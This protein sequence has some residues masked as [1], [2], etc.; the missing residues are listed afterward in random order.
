M[1]F[2]QPVYLHHAVWAQSLRKG[3]VDFNFSFFYPTVVRF[4]EGR[5]TGVNE[6]FVWFP[7]DYSWD[8]FD[9]D[10]YD[11]F[12]FH[13]DQ[14]LGATLFKEHAASVPLIAHSGR[15]WLY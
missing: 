6:Q 5:Q 9:G 7:F 1:H 12:L 10:V 14:D 15:W 8:E 11:Y 3:I 4:R 2:Q 13:A